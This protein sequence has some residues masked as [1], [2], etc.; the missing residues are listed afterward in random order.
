MTTLAHTPQLALEDA[1][2]VEIATASPY[3]AK[4]PNKTLLPMTA[5]RAVLARSEL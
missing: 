2:H 1:D 3:R 4:K 5:Q